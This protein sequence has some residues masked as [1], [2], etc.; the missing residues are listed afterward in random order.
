M[1]RNCAPSRNN[2]VESFLTYIRCELNLSA[3][4]VLSYGRN[5]RQWTEF[6]TGGRPDSF[7]PFSVTPS[8]L[9]VWIAHL[10][11]AGNSPRT[12]RLK[13][14]TLRAFFRYLMKQHGLKSNPAA[15]LQLAKTDRPLPVFVRPA[16]TAAI[17]DA[18]IPDTGSFTDVRNHLMLLMLYSTGMRSAELQSLLDADVDTSAMRL[19]VLGKRN[20]ERIIPFGPELAQAVNRYRAVRDAQL[21]RPL[22]PELFLRPDGSP[23]YRRLIYKIIHDML[24]E[25]GAHA[26]RLSPHVMRHSFATDMLNNGADLSAVQHLLGHSSLATTQIYTHISYRELRRD[27]LAAHPR[28]RR[29]DSSP[30]GHPSSCPSDGSDPSD[31]PAE[32]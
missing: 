7:D 10:A 12:L 32:P 8:D 21:P 27:Y 6:A 13:V 25:G 18:E 20:K 19:K 3:L 15:E 4:T 1:C 26:A 22:S 30:A 11:A 28:A 24:A 14:Q 17:L 31:L 29:P 9:R 16:E 23:L 5:L 2:L